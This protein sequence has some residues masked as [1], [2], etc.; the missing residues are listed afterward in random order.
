M[1]LTDSCINLV[2]SCISLLQ[3]RSDPVDRVRGLDA[4]VL[5]FEFRLGQKFV[6]VSKTFIFSAM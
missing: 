1:I 3:S 4:G 2:K 5:G 6:I